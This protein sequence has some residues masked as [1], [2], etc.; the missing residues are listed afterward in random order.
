M[1]LGT[2]NQMRRRHISIASMGIAL[3]I[4]LISWFI[5]V[6]TLGIFVLVTIPQ[7]KATFLKN[8]DSKANSVAVSL[9]DVTAGAAINEDFASLV[10]ASQ[11]LLAGD[12]ELE[13]L[14]IMKND[15]FALISQQTGWKV[16]SEIEPFWRSAERR[17]SGHIVSV[18]SLNKR[19]FHHAQ[20]FD[21]SGIEW[22]WIHVGLSLQQFDHSVAVLYRRTLWLGIGCAVFSLAVCLAYAHQLVKPIVRLRQ[23]VH[24]IAGGNLAVRAETTRR[25]EL[26]SLAVSVNLMTEGLL[27]RDRILESVRYAAQ[28][29]LHSSHWEPVVQ[30]VLA[31]I[32]QAANARQAA[33]FEHRTD[34]AGA[35]YGCLRYEWGR[36]DAKLFNNN[37]RM[38]AIYRPFSGQD[39]LGNQLWSNQ[40]VAGPVDSMDLPEKEVVMEHGILSVVVIPIFSDKNW[41]GSICLGDGVRERIW[42]ESEQDSLRTAADMFGAAVSRQRA[43]EAL[44]E[45][46][47]TLEH[48]VEE[49]TMELMDQVAAKEQ[50]LSRL[51]EAQDSLLEMSRAAGMAE[52]AT[53]VLH[54]IGNVL[55][56]VNVSCNLLMDQIRRSRVENVGKVAQLLD[57]PEGDLAHFVTED[58]RGRQIPAYLDSLSATLHKEH[59]A[60]LAEVESLHN[61]IEH[62]KEVVTMQQPFGRISGVLETYAAERLMED[63]LALNSGDLVR[64]GVT[65][66][67]D[68]ESVPPITTDKHKVLQILLNLINN[69]KHA[70]AENRG[71]RVITL[72]IFNVNHDRVAFQVKDTGIG[73]PPDNMIRIFQHGFTTRSNGHGFGLH[74]GALAARD[75]GGRLTVDSDGPGLGATFTLEIPINPGDQT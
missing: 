48:R 39:A 3:R 63:A 69:A 58:S 42:T 74:S 16:E 34:E 72:R 28:Q 22:G 45:A 75:L 57:R 47:A 59:R 43:Q 62:I 53:G 70:C 30:D 50:A 64:H 18:P 68:Y 10:S 5:A 73:I 25:D 33:L 41:W 65:T 7:Q 12:A 51:A 44:L 14:I 40:I 13:F 71:N 9:R 38:Q 61:K 31:K 37:P 26:G 36:T 46:K 19:V 1:L 23:V 49:R 20:P 11:T 17:P 2:H 15:G 27:R 32:G 6:G 60:M 54:N 4:A 56:S 8:L 67:R 35:L 52:V 66:V 21:Y 24:E 55:N 29:F